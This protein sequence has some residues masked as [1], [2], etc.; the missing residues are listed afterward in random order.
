MKLRFA[1]AQPLK[2]LLFLPLNL[3]ACL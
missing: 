1:P 2:F 3:S